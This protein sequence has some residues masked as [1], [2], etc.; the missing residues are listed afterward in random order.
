[1][2]AYAQITEQGYCCGVSELSGE[3][4]QEDMIPLDSFDTSYIG[5]KYDTKNKVWTDEYLQNEDVTKEPDKVEMLG[6]QL[7][8][9]EIQQVEYNI[10]ATQEREFSGQQLS[11]LEISILERGLWH[12]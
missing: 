10:Q 4:Q 7:S 11:D 5:R 9:L 2:F 8:D 6:Q 3:V 12:A 1:M